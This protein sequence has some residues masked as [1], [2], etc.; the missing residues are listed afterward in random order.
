MTDSP[1]R[2]CPPAEATTAPEQTI[3]NPHQQTHRKSDDHNPFSEL[4]SI[5]PL[6]VGLQD[7]RPLR[8]R[9]PADPGPPRLAGVHP[10]T[11]G[12]KQ[13]HHPDRP[14]TLDRPRSFR[15]DTKRRQ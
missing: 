2:A 5:R 6:D 4:N 15:N 7:L 8:G 1:T 14:S 11:V 3:T 10:Y 12:E 9:P 13:E